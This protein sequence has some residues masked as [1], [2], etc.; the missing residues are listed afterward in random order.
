MASVGL[1][2]FLCSE[3]EFHYEIRNYIIVL[4]MEKLHFI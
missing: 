2:H 4:I 3:D 1:F